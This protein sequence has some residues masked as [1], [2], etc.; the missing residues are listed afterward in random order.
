MAL[1]RVSASPTMVD[2]ATVEKFTGGHTRV[3]WLT[4]ADNRDSFAERNNL[5]LWGYDSR[6]GRGERIIWGDRANYYR[7][8][9]TP[10]GQQIVFSNRQTRKIFVI[11]W[12]GSRP[13]LLK[14]P[15]CASQ[16]WRDPQ[17][18]KTWVYYQENPDD[19]TKP[20]V[21]FPIDEPGK[22]Q[23]VWS[24]SL[25][26]ALPSFQL[27]RDGKMAASTFPWPNSGVA[28]LPDVAWRK[29]RD[30]CWPAMAPR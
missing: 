22:V 7:P 2:G 20:V 23:T 6:D 8:L 1:Q 12:D 9:I 18:G 27:S 30:G 24:S 28:E 10:D 3:V 11:K 21:R 5:Q 25:V 19:F 29:H 13:R 14:E 15:G 16:V 17:T 26:Q 4:D